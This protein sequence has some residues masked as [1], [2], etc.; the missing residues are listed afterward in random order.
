MTRKHLFPNSVNNLPET[1]WSKISPVDLNHSSTRD[2]M[3]WLDVT[4][5]CFNPWRSGSVNHQKY[6]DSLWR[7]DYSPKKKKKSTCCYWKIKGPGHCKHLLEYNHITN[8]IPSL[9]LTTSTRAS[10]VGIL[11]RTVLHLKK[12]WL[13]EGKEL[14]QDQTASK[15]QSQAPHS[16]IPPPD[17]V[18]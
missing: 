3:H 7:V 4:R 18:H 12:L 9:F 15:L 11:I 16:D 5:L 6:I 8:L 14:S 10:W 2:K 13:R 1:G 17:L